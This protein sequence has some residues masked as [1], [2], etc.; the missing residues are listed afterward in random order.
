LP[1]KGSPEAAAIAIKAAI[2]GVIADLA[3]ELEAE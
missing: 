2:E 1:E 3:F